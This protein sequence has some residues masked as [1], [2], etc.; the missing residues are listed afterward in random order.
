MVCGT[1]IRSARYS[2]ALPSAHTPITQQSSS[3]YVWHSSVSPVISSVGDPSPQ[4]MT[5]SPSSVMS[6][7]HT[8][9]SSSPGRSGSGGARGFDS[10]IPPQYGSGGSTSIAIMRSA[11][12]TGTGVINGPGIGGSP[13][14]ICT[15]YGPTPQR[16]PDCPVAVHRYGFAS[17][18]NV[19]SSPPRL[20]L[21]TKNDATYPHWPSPPVS[22]LSQVPPSL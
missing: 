14:F 11:E 19:I 13:G 9:M 17:P 10:G 1:H 3:V 20:A 6:V 4:S 15:S 18:P 16:A 5:Q 22:G 12:S 2:C 7:A 21:V 8:V